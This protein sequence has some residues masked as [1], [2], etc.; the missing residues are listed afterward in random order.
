M[1]QLRRIALPKLIV[2]LSLISFLLPLQAT[3]ADLALASVSAVA[4]DVT[5]SQVLLEQNADIVLPI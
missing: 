5:D 4:V 1:Q 3:G 2:V